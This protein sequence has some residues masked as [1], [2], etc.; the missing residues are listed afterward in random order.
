MVSGPTSPTL[1]SAAPGPLTTL[2]K[3]LPGSVPQHRPP[4]CWEPPWKGPK[5]SES[6]W[7]SAAPL[8]GSTALRT[9]VPGI[10]ETR[11]H[12]REERTLLCG[13]SRRLPTGPRAPLRPAV[14]QN[15][16]AGAFSRPLGRA[17]RERREE[18]KQAWC[19]GRSGHRCTADPQD[20][21]YSAW[22]AFQSPR[23]VTF[24]R[25]I[26]IREG[27]RTVPPVTAA[28]ER[29]RDVGPRGCCRGNRLLRNVFPGGRGHGWPR[30]QQRALRELPFTLVFCPTR[31]RGARPRHPSTC[32]GDGLENQV[33]PSPRQVYGSESVPRVPSASAAPSPIVLV[34][35][36]Q[37]I[38]MLTP[39]GESGRQP[40]SGHLLW[41]LSS[42]RDAGPRRRSHTGGR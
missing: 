34:R 22:F 9:E 20:G 10:P 42:V 25:I 3:H 18:E 40:L 1:A 36:K 12:C 7:S 33:R 35:N 13:S 29:D 2:R 4:S 28:D 27:P 24:T 31:G 26:P 16:S 19:A 39:L 8:S 37:T 30:R 17:D 6:S 5:D 21:P 11:A 38:V 32:P 14:P 15:P 41:P 23:R